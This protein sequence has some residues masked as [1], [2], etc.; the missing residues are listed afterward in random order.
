MIRVLLV[1][2]GGMSS[3]MLV[4]SMEEEARKLSIQL[5]IES[6]GSDGIEEKLKDYDIMLVA[7]QVRHRFERLEE[8]AVKAGIPSAIIE[9]KDYGLMNG[10]S[11]L[12]Q[13]QDLLTKRGGD[14][15]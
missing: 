2:S 1:C 8:F 10:K 14:K 11:V 12:E 13:V 3:S 4:R 5:K 9:P 7:P 6:S 15:L